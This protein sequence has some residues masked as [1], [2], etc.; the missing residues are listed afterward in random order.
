MQTVERRHFPLQRGQRVL[1]L[2]CGEGRHV[3]AAHALDGVDAI[4]VDLSA[5]DLTELA[6]S[7]FASR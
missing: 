2:G 7:R 3:I 6:R 5:D 4:G 1:D